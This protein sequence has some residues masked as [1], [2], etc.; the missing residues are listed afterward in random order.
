MILMNMVFIKKKLSSF[1][2]TYIIF[3][4]GRGAAALVAR[5]GAHPGGGIRGLGAAVGA[6]AAQAQ[7]A[8]AHIEMLRDAA[9]GW[10]W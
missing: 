4:S 7:V 2:N 3:H 10:P 1:V 9:D 5:A 6:N 8:A